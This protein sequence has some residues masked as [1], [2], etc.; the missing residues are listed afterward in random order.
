[1]T[2]EVLGEWLYVRSYK[3]ADTKL[4]LTICI[5]LILYMLCLIANI[6]ASV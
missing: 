5:D 6:M 3:H 2:D 1:M 4:V